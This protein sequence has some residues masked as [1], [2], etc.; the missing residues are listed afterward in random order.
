M[1]FYFKGSEFTV[2]CNENGDIE[3]YTTLTA[4][5]SMMKNVFLE[6]LMRKFKGQIFIHYT[7]ELM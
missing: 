7:E 2:E 6:S 4:F 1:Y 3:L 5:K